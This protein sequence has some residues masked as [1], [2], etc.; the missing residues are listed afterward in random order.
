MKDGQIE[1]ILGDVWYGEYALDVKS[2]QARIRQLIKEVRQA[3]IKEV[4]DWIHDNCL[5]CSSNTPCNKDK[6]LGFHKPS[7]QAKLKEWDV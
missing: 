4:V 7:W 6:Y 5:G 3:G 2:R 1:D